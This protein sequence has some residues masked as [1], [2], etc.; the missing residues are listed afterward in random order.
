MYPVS[1]KWQ[2]EDNLI[3][4]NRSYVRIVFG[5]QDPD[6]P[7]LSNPSDN[8]HLLYSAVESVDL[9]ASAPFTYQTLER[10]RFILD[11]TN[12]LPSDTNYTYQGY[13]GNLISD[14]NGEWSIPPAVTIQ[15]DDYVSM[16]ALT[17]EFDKNFNEYPE[18]IK[19]T[20][21]KD[22]EVVLDKTKYPDDTYY[23][24]SEQIP[25]CT[26]ITIT[27]L[28]SKIPHRRARLLSLIYGII[29]D[30]QSQDIVTC[31]S[32]KE[33]DL[34]SSKL[35]KQDFEFTIVDTEMKY[36]PENPSGV[37]E[38]LESRQPVTYY[39]GYELSNGTIEWIPWGMS[40]STGDITVT[41]QQKMSNV[42]VKCAGLA[43]HLNMTYTE[44]KYYPEGIS[45]YDLADEVMNFSGFSNLIELDDSLKQIYT[46]N[47]L[48]A[49]S[50][51]ECLQ[52]IANAGRCIISYSRGGY[53]RILKED[54]ENVGFSFDFH[55]METPETSKIAPLR[56][57]SGSY[58][59]Y[60]VESTVSNAV[61][62]VEAESATP[63]E[64]TFEH[65]AYTNLSIEL[66][67]TLQMTGTPKYFAYKTVVTLSG[68]GTV[69]IKGNK[70]VSN[71]VSYAKQ[72]K[73]VGEDLEGLTN[74]LIDNAEDMVE[75]IDWTAEYAM[76]RTTYKSNDRGY[77]QL[78]CGDKVGYTSNFDNDVEVTL[79][80]QT[81]TYNG[82][83]KGSGE[84]IIE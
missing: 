63:Q 57:V 60:T 70:L 32:T 38:Y 9:G 11:G 49:Q 59:S 52:V 81:L 67:G 18:Q 69:T 22:G 72:F 13:V 80:K 30:L 27:W 53:L 55:K 44:G 29:N 79:V 17:L 15:F 48:S 28:K 24:V 12:P 50:V 71:T 2:E 65:S 41:K 3:L 4:R 84:F 34:I 16:A 61:D 10:N 68:S 75:Y 39:Y 35:P 42:T 31:K 78:D 51:G 6:A 45:L 14:D 58:T 66:S 64:F 37:W 19:I 26:K 76:R 77:P 82:A 8:G 23:V 21:E 40:Y 73:E 56:K 25:L 1:E 62:A 7:A 36:D 46:H 20:A 83:I 47:P 74:E 43:E 54:T 5:I 33:I